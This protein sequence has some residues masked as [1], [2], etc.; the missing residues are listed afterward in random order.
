MFSWKNE[1]GELLMA[2]L[3]ILKPCPFCKRRPKPEAVEAWTGK[4]YITCSG[5]RCLATGP[6]RSK[7][8]LAI[9]AWER[10]KYE[11]N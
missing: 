11:R 2:Q 7:P 10:L 6:L 1:A 9:D 5:L 4:Y 3:K 8:S